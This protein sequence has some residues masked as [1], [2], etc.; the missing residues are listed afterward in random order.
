[1]IRTNKRKL[2][3]KTITCS[4]FLL[5]KL[6][7]KH[8]RLHTQACLLTNAGMASILVFFQFGMRVR[9]S[10]SVC[11]TPFFLFFS[12][13]LTERD[14]SLPVAPDKAG[15]FWGRHTVKEAES[16]PHPR[17]AY[18]YFYL[19]LMAISFGSLK[20]NRNWRVNNENKV[21]ILSQFM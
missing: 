16:H 21:Y 6:R 12:L 7:F 10:Q 8:S 20:Y 19:F 17:P 3:A 14:P 18:T 9:K 2:N 5:W 1:M 11:L 15:L 4:I 13:C